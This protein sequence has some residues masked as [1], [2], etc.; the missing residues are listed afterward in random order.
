M[1][2]SDNGGE[3]GGLLGVDLGG[4]NLRVAFAGTDGTVLAETSEP[5]ADLTAERFA[6]R[7]VSI[8]ARLSTA[9]PLVVGVGVPAPATSDGRI[10][11]FVN[12][13]RLNGAPLRALLEARLGVPVTVEND[14]NLAALAE[15]HH[16][17]GR[18]ARDLVFIAVGTGVGMGIIA[19]GQIVRGATGG[20]GEIGALPL[21]V[22]HVAT[23]FAQLGPLESVAGGAGL[24]AQWSRYTGH[25][26]TGRDVFAAADGGDESA[27]TLLEEQARALAMAIRTVQALLEPELVVFGGGMGA[28]PDVVERVRTVLGGQELPAP[29]IAISALGE[30]AG[31]I[32]ALE[33]A[34]GALPKNHQE[35]SRVP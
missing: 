18:G 5:A 22:D 13:P 17:R 35:A 26:A 15:L 32:G 20:A 27:L 1:E 24:A 23:D 6:D 3:R 4:T 33:A 19:G 14:V 34:R 31:I 29:A 12:A 11:A 16:G 8:A 30:R 2:T 21:S 9:R 28:R 10:G 25:P 7:V